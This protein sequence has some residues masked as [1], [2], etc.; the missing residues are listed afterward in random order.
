MR[1]N[2]IRHVL[3]V[4]I[5]KASVQP[6]AIIAIHSFVNPQLTIQECNS[7]SSYTFMLAFLC[8]PLDID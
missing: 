7:A 4:P 3:T 8:D 1:C 5:H 2:K 6:A